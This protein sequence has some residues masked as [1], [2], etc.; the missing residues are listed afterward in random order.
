V[1]VLRY[2]ADLTVPQ[3]ADVLAVPVGTVKSRLHAAG[4]AMKARL[5]NEAAVEAR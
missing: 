5:E 2:Y 4:R 3:M 1:L